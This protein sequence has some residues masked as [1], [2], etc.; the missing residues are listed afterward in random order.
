MAKYTLKD[1]KTDKVVITTPY[2]LVASNYIHLNNYRDTHYIKVIGD[3]TKYTF[4]MFQEYKKNNKSEWE[5]LR[6]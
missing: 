1:L 5:H 6:G 3:K 4:E 2:I